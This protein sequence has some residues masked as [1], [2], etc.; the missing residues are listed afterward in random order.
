[1]QEH[2]LHLCHFYSFKDGLLFLFGRMQDIFRELQVRSSHALL[3]RKL[4]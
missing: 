4:E 2:V 1:M 3:V